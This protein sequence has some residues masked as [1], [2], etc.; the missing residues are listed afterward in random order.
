MTTPSDGA[1]ARMETMEALDRVVASQAPM[2][3]TLSNP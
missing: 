2:S 1:L 3:R